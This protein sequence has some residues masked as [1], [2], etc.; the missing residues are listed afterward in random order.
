[1][2]EFVK[3]RRKCDR[4]AISHRLGAGLGRPKFCDG[5][6]GVLFGPGEFRACGLG[7]GAGI[8]IGRR[9][10]I[11]PIGAADWRVVYRK[12]KTGKDHETGAVAIE[13]AFHACQAHSSANA[14][15]DNEPNARAVNRNADR[16]GLHGGA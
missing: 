15:R 10:D 7:L 12:P 16:W 4:L 5:R 14:N 11:G 13:V 1:M 9:C 6:C 2:H 8:D 3:A